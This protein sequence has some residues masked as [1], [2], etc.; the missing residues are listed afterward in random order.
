MILILF[1]YGEGEYLD[2]IILIG[3]FNGAAA[4]LVMGEDNETTE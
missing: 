2:L 3:G 1:F 4:C